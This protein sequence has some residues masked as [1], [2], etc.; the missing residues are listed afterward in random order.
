MDASQFSR[1]TRFAKKGGIGKCVALKNCAAEH[2]GDLMFFKGDEIT[3]LMQLSD[4]DGLFLG[5][6]EGVVGRFAAAY[7]QFTGK[8]KT[9]IISKRSSSTS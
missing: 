1:W 5:Y 8:L 3:V 7:V 6:C 9:P 2:P 4:E